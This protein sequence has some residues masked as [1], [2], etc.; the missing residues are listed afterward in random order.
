MDETDERA[1]ALGRLR[2]LLDDMGSSKVTLI[3]DVMLDRFHHGY[4]NNLDSTAPVPVLKILSSEETPGAAAHI[5]MGLN[6]LGLQVELH[7]CVGD[8]RE[9]RVITEKL[10]EKGIEIS[11]IEVVPERSTLTKIRFYGSRES[12]LDKSQI[13]LQ[14]D[15]GPR[16]PLPDSVC[17]GLTEQA[18]S[19]L[20]DSCAIV[21][22][23]YDKGVLNADGSKALI[24]AAK[25]AELPVI[26]D[27]KL[28]GL[29]R[30]RGADVVLFE[31]RGLELL[32]RRQMTSN[33]ADAARLLIVEYGWGSML[34][35]GGIHGVTLYQAGL[36]PMHIPCAAPAPVQQIG[37]HDA[38]ATA[39]AAALGNG[40]S[41]TD[42]AALAAAACECVL[43]AEASHEFVDRT[44]LGLW[45][46][47]LAWQLQIS[48]R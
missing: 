6:S 22:S 17:E 9:G 4:A 48:D 10:S 15:R 37:L 19:S 16:D 32:S 27:P 39:L 29:D 25:E 24:E 40:L 46:D 14:A 2:A 35:L 18:M 11:G 30:S 7:C 20:K 26:M 3:G 34:V 36:E 28:T 31:K 33:L 42:A 38:A 21:L 43:T 44:T 23:D 5:A 41:I 1:A 45:L 12:L 13:L 47:E 8:D